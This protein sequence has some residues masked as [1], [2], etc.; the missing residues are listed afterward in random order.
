MAASTRWERLR[1]A[2]FMRL[3]ATALFTRDALGLRFAPN[4]PEISHR[5]AAA[6]LSSRLCHRLLIP[7]GRRKIEAQLTLPA[8][9]PRALVLLCHGIGERLS[10]WTQVQLLLADA[11]IGSLVFHYSSYGQS[12]GPATTDAFESDART[13]YAFL[14]SLS[15]NT[16]L[17]LFGTSL[18][19]AVAAHVAGS[20][21]PQPA[22][23][24]LSQG[25]PSLR[26]ASA[27]VLA[28]LG[29]RHPLLP[30]VMPD[31][32]R[33]AEAVRSVR[34]PILVVHSPDDELFPASMGEALYHAAAQRPSCRQT[35]VSPSGFAHNDVS[36]RP[37]L[38]YWS[39]I[40][41]FILAE[42]AHFTKNNDA[43]ILGV[44]AKP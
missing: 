31:L 14:A 20:I 7:A 1:F 11:A 33:S 23:L 38:G 40:M 16:P 17:F 42:A 27:A 35:F 29:I 15:P 19:S 13:A 43:A 4:H 2:L 36:L 24:I 5:R 10:F 44:T 22:G 39:P 6:A 25:F 8:Q 3:A 30:R 18:G 12:R 37:S 34:C 26:A 41:D 9:P 21:D 32:W 28:L